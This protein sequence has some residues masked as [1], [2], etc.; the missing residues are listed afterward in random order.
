MP[1][2]MPVFSQTS[3]HEA[4][5]ARIFTTCWPI[6]FCCASVMR[7]IVS[8]STAAALRGRELERDLVLVAIMA[9]F[10]TTGGILRKTHRTSTHKHDATSFTG[11]AIGHQ[12]PYGLPAAD[13]R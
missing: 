10:P 6:F 12:R 7:L 5:A 4:P 1:P 8:F 3:V 13:A 9:P 2:G 11:E